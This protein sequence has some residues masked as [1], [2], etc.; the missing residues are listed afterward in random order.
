MPSTSSVEKDL[1]Y[2]LSP[3]E[4][5]RAL[6]LEL[7]GWQQDVLTTPSRRIALNCSRQSGKT[8][9]AVLASLH[10]AL[11][12]AKQVVLLVSPSWRQSAESIRMAMHFLGQLDIQLKP[13]MEVENKLSL[14]FANG[15]RLISLPSGET[16]TRGYTANLVVL[17]EASRILDSMFYSVLMPMVSVTG[18]TVIMLSSPAG[19]R[20]FFHREFTNLSQPWHRIVVT[21]EQCPR[22]TAAALAEQRATLGSLVYRQEFMCEFVN[23]E[24]SVFDLAS[25]DNCFSDEVSP[26]FIEDELMGEVPDYSIN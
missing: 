9:V 17:D 4:F 6:G 13:E 16:T 2:A 26:L 24:D 5:A 7:D 3:V 21:A 11:Y 19:M 15:S 1:K 25:V 20:G 23:A 8:S 12:T 14:E 22:L 10:L 18:G